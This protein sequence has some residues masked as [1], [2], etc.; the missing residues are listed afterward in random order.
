M[1]TN[2]RSIETS[3]KGLYFLETCRI[4]QRLVYLFCPDESA[5]EFQ[6]Q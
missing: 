4:K 6:F 1:G 2:D 5:G 3:I